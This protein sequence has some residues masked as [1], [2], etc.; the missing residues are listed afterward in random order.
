M[1]FSKPFGDIRPSSAPGDKHALVG[2]GFVLPTGIQGGGY[3][4]VPGEC[5]ISMIAKTP[6][7]VRLDDVREPQSGSK[8][9]V[10][11]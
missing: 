1:R 3:S 9:R 4:A 10:H 8:G 11:R 2:S 7:G 6:P 5:T